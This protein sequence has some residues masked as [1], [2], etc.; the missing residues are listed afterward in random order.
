[1]KFLVIADLH[2]EELVLE[3]LPAILER[4]KP[5]Y[6]IIAGDFTKPHNSSISYAEDA[7]NLYENILA[8]PGNCDPPKILELIEERGFSIHERKKDIGE[9]LN[10]V[11]FGYSGPTPFGT[12]GE[13]GEEEILRR[14]SKLSIN[15]RS[16]LVTHS[17]PEGILDINFR[18]DH[19]GSSSIKEIVEGK[20]PFLHL[21]AH[22]HECEGREKQGNTTF[23][24][25][26]PAKSGKALI[27]D[28]KNQK[29]ESRIV[30]L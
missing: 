18:G 29:I 24:K 28:I 15:E 25:I 10:I 5:D 4:E 22:V 26:P 7:L 1:M 16:I 12:P 13:L 17:P 20:G 9:G 11:G 2:E 6:L 19:L 23:I 3:K 14:M 27:I 21:F 30:I 8:I